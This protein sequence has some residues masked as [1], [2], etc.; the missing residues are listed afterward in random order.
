NPA[1]WFLPFGPSGRERYAQGPSEDY[2]LP[3]MPENASAGLQDPGGDKA[4][5]AREPVAMH[6]ISS[7]AARIDHRRNRR[8]SVPLPNA[9]SGVRH[10]CDQRPIARDSG[11]PHEIACRRYRKWAK[12]AIRR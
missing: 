1:I 4:T 9:D 6:K 10:G 5:A 3:T 11:N 2:I 12:S 8:V 7:S